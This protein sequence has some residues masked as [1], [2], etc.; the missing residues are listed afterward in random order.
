MP[1][2]EE[3]HSAERISRIEDY[4]LY[5]SQDVRNRQHCG[6]IIKWSMVINGE[7]Q[8]KSGFNLIEEI[9]RSRLKMIPKNE[10]VSL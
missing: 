2:F 7:H 6:L 8:F 10:K 5:Y 4:E 3:F 1:C 9:H